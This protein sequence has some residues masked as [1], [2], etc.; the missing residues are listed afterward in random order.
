VNLRPAQPYPIAESLAEFAL[1]GGHF[2]EKER[3][4]HIGDDQGVRHLAGRQIPRLHAVQDQ[5]T[6]PHGSGPQWE[7]ERRPD[8]GAHRAGREHRPSAVIPRG[9]QIGNQHW[10]SGAERVQARAFAQG[11]LRFLD[12]GGG[13]VRRVPRIA[14]SCAVHQCQPRAACVDQLNTSIAGYLAG[15]HGAVSE[16]VFHDVGHHSNQPAIGHGHRLS[17]LL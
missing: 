5:S 1:H 3:Q 10:Y 11:E 7:H 6:Q 15:D 13:L 2:V 4:D 14:S 12:Q 9:V 16:R 17:Q 8:A